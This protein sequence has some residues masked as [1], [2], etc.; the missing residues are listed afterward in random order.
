M[1]RMNKDCHAMH[2]VGPIQALSWCGREEQFRFR[3]KTRHY[4]IELEMP[5]PTA[6]YVFARHL[7]ENSTCITLQN[8]LNALSQHIAALNERNPSVEPA[9]TSLD[10]W[11]NQQGPRGVLLQIPRKWF[12]A[13]IA[14]RVSVFCAELDWSAANHG[15]PSPA[16]FCESRCRHNQAGRCSS[17]RAS[18][19]VGEWSCPTA[20]R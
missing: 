12:L 6:A 13:V 18:D 2:L 5:A 7:H 15:V 16:G 11:V 1:E 14:L 19:T 20:W 10:A 3:A 4:T 9:F 17:G 8:D